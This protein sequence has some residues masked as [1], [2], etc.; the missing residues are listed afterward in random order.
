MVT[1]LLEMVLGG[2]AALL[3]W[4]VL[5]PMMIRALPW[6]ERVLPRDIIGPDAWF[7]DTTNQSGIFDLRSKRRG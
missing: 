2:C 5:E 6:F 3:A 4:L 7:A 1:L